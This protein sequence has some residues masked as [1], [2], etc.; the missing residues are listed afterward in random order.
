MPSLGAAVVGRDRLQPR[1]VADRVAGGVAGL[2]GEAGSRRRRRSGPSGRGR[3]SRGSARRRPRRRSTRACCGSATARAAATISS[4]SKPSRSPIRR[5]ASLDLL[6]ACGSAGAR[7]GGPARGRRGRAR[8][9]GRSG[10]GRGRRRAQ[11]LDRA[12]LGE[13][14]LRFGD[15]GAHPVARAAPP[16]T[17]TTRPSARATP[18]PPKASESISTSSSSPRR[19]PRAAGLAGGLSSSQLFRARAR[20]GRLF[21]DRLGPAADLFAGLFDQSFEL[22]EQRVGLFA[23]AFDQV[24]E[25]LLGVA[26]G[27]PAALDGVVD[28]LLEAVAAERDAL[29]EA[30]A[31]LG[32]ALVEAAGRFAAGVLRSRFFRRRFSG[33]AFSMRLSRGFFRLSL[34]RFGAFAFARFRLSALAFGFRL[35]F[36]LF[37]RLLFSRPSR[38]PPVVE[39]RAGAGSTISIPQHRWLWRRIVASTGA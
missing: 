39:L 32:D 28:D 2:G 17:K 12:R 7:R 31:E 27:H 26:A 8:R 13:A 11:Q 33:F 4:S 36:C 25:H 30:L 22:A 35:A 1:P 14:L 21:A 38:L 15:L 18:R 5:S 16:A 34:C 37:Y 20:L 24:A 10:R 19:G 23:A 6:A 3:G 9:R 29:L